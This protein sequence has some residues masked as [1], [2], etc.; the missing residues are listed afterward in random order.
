MPALPPQRPFGPDPR[1]PYPF[2]GLKRVGFLNRLIDAP[3]VVVGDYTYYDDPAGPEHFVERCVT[4]HPPAV[5]DR[6]V[7]GRYCAIATGVQFIMNAS[8]HRLDGLSTYPFAIFR[9]GW[10]DSD[11]AWDRTRRG[12]TVVGN[13]VWIGTQATIMPGITVGDGAVIGAK[14]VVASDVPPYATVVGNP[15]RIIRR[16]FDAA[17]VARLQAIAWWDWPA[18]K[19][20]RHL[21]L[22]RGD[23]VEALERAAAAA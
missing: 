12:D 2:P 1:D 18:E 16:R 5:G 7:I 4:Y 14:A 22:I 6:L 21:E 10:E 13:D 9:Q 20:T 23:D 8:N 17:T 3:H 11:D 19:V 15:A